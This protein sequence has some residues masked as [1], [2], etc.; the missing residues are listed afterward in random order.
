MPRAD[1]FLR[2]IVGR[3]VT[4]FSGVPDSLLKD[5]YN[6]LS[7]SGLPN[8]MAA[9]EG[10]ALALAAG[11]YAA[12]GDPG[13]VYVQ[14]SGLGNL[15]NPTLSLVDPHV[16]GIPVVLL[17]GW[18]GQPGTADEPQHTRQGELTLP[19]LETLGIPTWVLRG[20]Q[21]ET[22]VNAAVDTAVGR[23]GPV[24]IV[25]PARYFDPHP[26]SDNLASRDASELTREEA[27]GVVVA[28][29]GERDVLVSTTGMLSR[30][31]FELR[32]TVGNGSH[33]QDFLTVGSMGHAISIAHGMALGRPDRRIICLDGD[34]SLLMHMGSAAIA[35]QNAPANL[36]HIVFNNGVHDSVGAQ[37]TIARG[38][39]LTML[40]ASL[41][42]RTSA[43]CSRAADLPQAV[44]DLL[45][46]AGPGF[47]E[48]V[49]RPGARPN[50]GRPTT[51]PAEN[52]H[53]LMVE[54]G[55]R[56]EH[57]DDDAR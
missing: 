41:G 57:E 44:D 3:G 14:N 32:E 37:P 36:Y 8:V 45:Q 26:R 42:Y 17:I 19:L 21:Q 28:A 1:Q 55:S 50:L 53:A 16:Y 39:N 30:E 31:L 11:H 43:T 2:T 52:L 49:V 18:R 10:G 47:L 23:G 13:M 5:F 35:A 29:G 40:S 51:T 20:D 34:G 54:L 48:I 38:L 27:L 33:A 12:T 46:G 9:N 6:A 15:V 25:V 24:A 22:I 4:F 7:A 56:R